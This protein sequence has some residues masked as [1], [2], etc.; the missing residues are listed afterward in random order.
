MVL[1][2]NVSYAVFLVSDRYDLPI[3]RFGLVYGRDHDTVIYLR[4]SYVEHLFSVTSDDFLFSFQESP[5]RLVITFDVSWSVY[6]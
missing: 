3:L 6:G 5:G 4:R 2:V 1:S